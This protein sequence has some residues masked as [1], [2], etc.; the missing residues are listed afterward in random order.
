MIKAWMTP[1]MLMAVPFLGAGL[2]LLQRS[3]LQ[4]M[5]TWALLTAAASLLVV[6]GTPWAVGETPGGGR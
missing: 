1:W 3:S 5:N 2:G 4:R 6:L